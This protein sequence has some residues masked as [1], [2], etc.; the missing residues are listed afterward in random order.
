MGLQDLLLTPVYLALIVPFMFAIK[1]NYAKGSL[2]N[3][4]LP[5]YFLKV[6]GSIALGLIYFFYYRGGDTIQYFVDSTLMYK[7]FWEDPELGFRFLFGSNATD[8]L[9]AFYGS[10]FTYFKDPPSYMVVRFSGTIGIFTLNTYTLNAIFFATYSFFG[11]WRMYR[12]FVDQYPHLHKEFAYG[13][14]YVPSLFF[15][16]SGLMKDTITLGAL[17]FAYSGFYYG[18][19]KGEKKILNLIIL[20]VSCWLLKETKIYIFLCFIPACLLW[21]FLIYKD[22]IKVKVIRNTV[23]PIIIAVFSLAGFY[24]MSEISRG[25]DYDLNNIAAEAKITSD[26]LRKISKEG[27]SYDVGKLDGTFTGLLALAPNAIFIT[28]FRP[29]LWEINGPT[30]LLAALENLIVLMLL[31]YTFY[32]VNFKD[33]L[34]T[35]RDNHFV[36]VGLF[37]AIPFSFFMGVASG[38]F[39]TLVRY[40]IPMLPFFIC[41]IMVILNSNGYT[42]FKKRKAPIKLIR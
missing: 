28:L 1:L 22:K 18:I 19:I 13:F 40:K 11:C 24:G 34:K 39:G 42:L 31:I 17:G 32:K 16:G 3:Y 29:F 14:L 15:W 41:S 2:G 38:N 36:I 9:T 33:V 10:Q 6:I 27:A 37:F 21:L 4:F 23:A 26:Y 7:V 8:K 25:T 20:A 35:I 5:A 12:A 30:M